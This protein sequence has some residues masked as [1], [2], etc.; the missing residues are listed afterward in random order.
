VLLAGRALLIIAFAIA[1][2]GIAASLYGARTRNAPGHDKD[3]RA[4]VGYRDGRAWIASG[5]RSVYALAFT[6]VV[7]FAILEAA[8]LR[9]DFSFQLVAS[10]S[11]TTT[12][13]FYRATAVWSSQEGS[14][15]LWAMLL[16]GWSSLILFVTRRRAQEI[17]PYAT[18]V[19]LGLAAFF[20]GLLVF[21]V[22]PFGRA[23]PVPVEG[24]GLEPLLR[25]PSMMFHPPMLYSGYTLFTVPFAFA[26]GAL[27]TRRLDA[28]WMRTT[29]P[30][31]LAAW[32]CL[33]VGIVLGARWSYS[34]L[35][36]G[37]YWGWD[38]VEN[39]SLM[40]WLTG[41]AF[42]HS[43][44][45]QEK[46]GMLKLWNV[47][48]VLATGVLAILG[49]FLV[50]SGILSSIHAFGASTLGVPFVLLIAAM[51]LGSVVLVVTRSGQL[52]AEHRLDSLLSR[53]AVF[54][55][56]NFVLVALCFVIFW[57]TF[58]P[59]ISEAITGHRAS[60]G[61]PWFDRY[62]APLAL[63]LVLLSGLGPVFAWRRTT[64]ASLRR[65][66]LIPVLA[67]GATLVALLAAGGVA[68]RPSALVMFCLAAFV[69]TVV[70]QEFWRGIVAR[71]AMSSDS[72]PKALV[73]LVGR[74]RRR[75]GGYVVHAGIAVLFVGLAAS[76]SFQQVRDVR[77]APGGRAKVG[78]YDIAYVRPTSR[79]HVTHKGSLE[80]IDLGAQLRVRR[81]DGKPITLRPARS[82]F[83]SSDPSLG[84]VSRYFEGE[85]TSEV[86]LRPGLRRDFWTAVSP[87][88]ASLGPVIRRGDDVFERARSLPAEERAVALG[89][90][91]R[92]IVAGYQ[93]NASAVTFRVLVSPLV[94]WIWLGA[95]IIFGGGLITL[96]P[97]P[98]GFRRRVRSTYA[99][100]IARELGR[101]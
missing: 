47:S 8:F 12:P 56:N 64:L 80:K 50:R 42:L 22:S 2:Y 70:G 86:G 59:L 67:A 74:N 65:A 77:L 90:A 94:T 95:V 27:V 79:L 99:A 23:S 31:A 73:S 85:A 53:E 101:A 4:R 11:S 41:T 33:G 71:R 82:F 14:L 97:A 38:G 9:S 81:G 51:V 20:C 28:E 54:L 24:L 98:A 25:H 6:L 75:Y 32:L 43:V 93:D 49:T 7:S 21:L 26:I 63:V 83:P 3:G 44:M 72:V 60:V 58:F 69:V 5:R 39:A 62:V 37:G 15:L 34:E 68:R 88:T 13:A 40:P 96:W 17:A 78:G 1:L 61:P 57:G 66:L 29:R 55:L 45:I 16:S 52:R 100:R 91:L 87:D 30:F 92:R 46:R 10:N 19:L 18:A 35:G 76:S 89:E 48:L 36:W 84:P